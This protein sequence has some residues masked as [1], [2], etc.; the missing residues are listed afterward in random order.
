PVS[1]SAIRTFSPTQVLFFLFTPIAL[2]V[3]FYLFPLPTARS[4]VALLSI[5]YFVDAI[6]N[7]FVV[8]K[9]MQKTHELRIADEDIDKIKEKKLPIYSILCPLYKEAHIVPQFLEGIAKI[10]WPKEKL[11]VMFLLEEDD[12]ETIQAFYNMTLPYYAR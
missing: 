9:S 3:L 10:D 5:F 7:M 12:T 8:L 6:F 11:D 2:L 4:L 1:L